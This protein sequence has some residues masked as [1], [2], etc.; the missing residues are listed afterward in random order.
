MSVV[1]RGGQIVPGACLYTE[2]K[3]G[4]LLKQ[5][6]TLN[7]KGCCSQYFAWANVAYYYSDIGEV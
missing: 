3:Q 7:D 2:I 1:Q 6:E 5:A 4:T